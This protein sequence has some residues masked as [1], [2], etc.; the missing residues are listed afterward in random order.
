MS[1]QWFIRGDAEDL[2]PYRPSEILRL[3]WEGAICEETMLRKGDSPWTAAGDVGG[4]FEAARRPTVSWTCPHCGRAIR[5]PPAYCYR[6]DRFVERAEKHVT[7]HKVP[8][9]TGKMNAVSK[10]SSSASNSLS[11]LF[12]R[13]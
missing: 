11:R 3:I 1:D 12:R 9:R 10:P 13:K 4:L 6:C 8:P 5:Q 7:E 2:G